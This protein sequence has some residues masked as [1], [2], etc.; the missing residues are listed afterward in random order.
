MNTICF[1]RLPQ[2]FVVGGHNCHGDKHMIFSNGSH[3]KTLGFVHILRNHF[4]LKKTVSRGQRPLQFV[5]AEDHNLLEVTE[6][7]IHGHRT[8]LSFFVAGGHNILK[9]SDM[10]T[11]YVNNPLWPEATAI[12]KSERNY[13]RPEVT[14]YRCVLRSQYP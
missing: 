7:H 8:P 11:Y 13:T 6:M 5:P 3:P 9:S 1:R 4:D 12:L 2:L 14:I 10:I